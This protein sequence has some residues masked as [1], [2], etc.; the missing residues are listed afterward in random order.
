MFQSRVVVSLVLLLAGVGCGLRSNTMAPDSGIS[1]SGSGGSVSGGGGATTGPGAPGAP[2]PDAGSVGE[3]GAS[4]PP[5]GA[6]GAAGNVGTGGMSELPPSDGGSGGSGGAIAGSTCTAG[7]ACLPTNLCHVGQSA[8]SAAGVAS[9]TDTNV[10]QPNG[11]MCG[12]VEG[13]SSMCTNGICGFTCNNG[14]L[15]CSGA[16]FCQTPSWSFEDGSAGGF[17]LSGKDSM[18]AATSVAVS[19]A[20]AHTGSSSLAI[21]VKAQGSK[22]NFEVAIPICGGGTG[23]AA[24]TGQMATAWFYVVPDKSSIERPPATSA[25]G[26]HLTTSAGDVAMLSINSTVVTWF[27]ITTPITNIGSQ[28]TKL[29]IDGSF[30]P[31]GDSASYDWTGTIYVDDIA[32]Q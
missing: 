27:Q 6:G 29:A 26:Q 32:F 18:S 30:G 22:R 14:R 3:G 20:F 1:T 11:T 25:F 17:A 16:M 31:A 24:G 21:T 15:K 2:H 23:F 28:I 12:V 13:G 19:K 9:C 7:K 4:A 10:A 5:T 8:C